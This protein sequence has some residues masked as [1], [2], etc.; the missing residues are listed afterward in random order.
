MSKISCT[1]SLVHN[2]THSSVC[3]TTDFARQKNL[4]KQKRREEKKKKTACYHKPCA[5]LAR[6]L[7]ITRSLHSHAVVAALA[8]LVL[9]WRRLLIVARLYNHHH[10][11]SGRVHTARTWKANIACMYSMYSSYFLA[12]RFF[13]PRAITAGT[14]FFVVDLQQQSTCFFFFC[15]GPKAAA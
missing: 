3:S 13:S 5:E 2:Y 11:D 8:H 10:H 12:E 14:P 6:S 9:S 1:P 15:H 7:A 4:K